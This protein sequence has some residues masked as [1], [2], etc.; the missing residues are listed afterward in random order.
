MNVLNLPLAEI[1]MKFCFNKSQAVL[2]Y[3]DLGLKPGA[4]MAEVKQVYR[5]RSKHL[6]PDKKRNRT[7]EEEDELQKIQTAHTRLGALKALIKDNLDDAETDDMKEHS[8]HH[9]DRA[10]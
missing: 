7:K 9:D 1:P 3:K 4:S 10:L 5:K 2:Y 8:S 6:H